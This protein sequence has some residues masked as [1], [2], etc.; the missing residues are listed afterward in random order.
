MTNE[1]EKCVDELLAKVVQ[2]NKLAEL[3]ETNASEQNVQQAWSLVADTN[4]LIDN[5][6]SIIPGYCLK[7]ACEA[8][9]TLTLKLEKPCKEEL[10]FKF[11]SFSSSK[12]PGS[13]G[14]IERQNENQPGEISPKAVIPSANIFGFQNKS[15]E[16]LSLSGAEVEFK[17]VSIVRLRNCDVEVRGLANT[18]YMNSLTDTRVSIYLASRSITVK[19]CENCKF[20]LIC[21]QLRI[22]STKSCEFEIFTS[23]RSMLESSQGLV[24]KP[25]DISSLGDVQ[26]TSQS[27]NLMERVKFDPKQNNW[28][29]I[30][31]FDWLSTEVASKNFTLV[32]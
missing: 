14:K 27:D 18:I 16:T 30:D 32:E 2:L 24:F 4:L 17:D 25:L 20:K 22:D 8:L 10:Q 11:K 21:Q 31:D 9:R 19:D 7:R 3:L 26:Q 1:S 13:T 29:C 6:R 5:N 23:A 15:D 12:Q 28:R